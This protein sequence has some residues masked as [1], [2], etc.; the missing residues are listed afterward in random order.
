M[1]RTLRKKVLYALEK[2]EYRLREV[3]F[4]WNA[5]SP[6]FNHDSRS[7]SRKLQHLT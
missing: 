5:D 6:L 3:Q 1:K 4:F 7:V 2:T